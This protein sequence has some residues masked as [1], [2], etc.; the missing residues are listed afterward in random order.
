MVLFALNGW[1]RDLE[2]FFGHSASA[3]RR[4]LE[5]MYR[6]SLVVLGPLLWE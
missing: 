2:V 5:E 3:R 1:M 6:E 4:Q